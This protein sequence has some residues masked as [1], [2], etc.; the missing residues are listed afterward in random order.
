MLSNIL[1]N[2]TDI[3]IEQALNHRL[4]TTGLRFP[5]LAATAADRNMS[6]EDVMALVE[7]EGW[8]Y[9]HIEPRDGRAYVCSAFVAAVYKAGG[10]LTNVHGTEFTPRDVYTLNI[11]DTTTPRPEACVDADPTLPYC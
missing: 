7:Q 9:Q 3:F 1:P 5:D 6:I 4:N 10:I 8:I 11:F 2:V